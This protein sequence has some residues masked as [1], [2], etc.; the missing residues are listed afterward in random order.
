MTPLVSAVWS[1]DPDHALDYP[2]RYL[3]RFLEH[4][5]MLT[6]FGSPTWRTVTG[7]SREYVERVAKNL[8]E[9]RL[10][11]PVSAIREHDDGV[12]VT[13]PSGTA[14]Y[15]AVVVATHPDQALAMLA[16]PTAAAPRGARR[17]PLR[18]PTSRSCTPTS[19]CCRGPRAP[20]PPGTTSAAP[21]HRRPGAGHLR[22]DPA[23]AARRQVDDDAAAFLVTLGAE[24]VVDPSTVIATM[25]YAHPIYTPASV[26][27]QARL[28][29]AEHRAAS[30]SPAPTT[31]G[32]STRTAR[33][34]AARRPST[35]ADA[36]PRSASARGR[37]R[38]RASTPPRSS[39]PGSSRCATSSATAATPGWSTST[40][41]RA[42]RGVFAPLLRRLASFEAR[43]HVG[44]PD[45]SLREN[46]DD[47]LAEHDIDL[48]GGPHPDARAPAH[49]R[50]RLQP[51]LGVLVPPARPRAGGGRGR[52]AQ[53]LR[54]APRLPRA[55]RRSTAG[56]A[57]TRSSTSRRSTTPPARTTSPSRCPARRSPSASPCTARAA[58]RS[59][60]R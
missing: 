32:A 38:P 28:P 10:S 51:D 24:D 19:G 16:E 59:P 40:T 37:R 9:V 11:S 58:R 41:C 42:T 55:P 1:T 14:T 18:S 3:F 12:D 6:V 53:H 50:L 5:G 43:D 21:P 15:D 20:A 8:H 47:F 35:S 44:D 27:A 57:S 33:S 13:D 25:H 60:R 49:P 26:A 7:G 34:P 4:H 23:A 45:R 54:R 36:G 29:R 56:R 17:D 48:Q 52:G 46:I 39:T 31:A 22:H 30:P 2:A